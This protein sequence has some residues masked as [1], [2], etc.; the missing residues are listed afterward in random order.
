MNAVRFLT[1]GPTRS[2]AISAAAT[3]VER[4]CGPYDCD[5]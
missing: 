4:V 2:G 1:P 3:Y 5:D